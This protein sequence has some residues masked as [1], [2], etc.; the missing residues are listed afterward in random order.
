MR[1]NTKLALRI[2]SVILLD[3][4]INNVGFAQGTA[5][6]SNPVNHTFSLIDQ[7]SNSG[8]QQERYEIIRDSASLHKTWQE[9]SAGLSPEPSEPNINFKEELLITAFAG[10]QNNGGYALSITKLETTADNIEVGVLLI[11]PGSQCMTSTVMTQPYVI[12]KTP[13]LENKPAHFN[14][15]VKSKNCATGTIE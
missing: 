1:H 15:T 9:H 4:V 11:K 6:T 5:F 2:T 13:V 10:T 3:I 14:V 8:V 12:A 7:G